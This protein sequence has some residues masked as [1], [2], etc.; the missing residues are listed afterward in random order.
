MPPRQEAA[1]KQR[2]EN[3]ERRKEART[4]T[5][6]ERARILSPSLFVF[7]ALSSLL[8]H[9]GVSRGSRAYRDALGDAAVIYRATDRIVAWLSRV[10]RALLRGW[11]GDEEK[12]QEEQERKRTGGSKRERERDRDGIPLSRLFDPRALPVSLCR[13][14]ILGLTL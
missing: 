12:R 8:R 14:S 11:E 9:P 6:C 13:A 4:G 7:L 2:G 5:E 1:W 10:L 3:Q